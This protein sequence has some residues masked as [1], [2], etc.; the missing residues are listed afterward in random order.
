MASV[1]VDVWEELNAPKAQW[2][3]HP[4]NVVVL[5]LLLQ[6]VAWDEASRGRKRAARA[7]VVAE[8]EDIGDLEHEPLFCTETALKVAHARKCRLVR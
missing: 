2:I 3:G 5:Q 8:Y 7:A 1:P 4:L 6:E